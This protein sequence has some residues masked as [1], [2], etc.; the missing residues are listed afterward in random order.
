M[1]T[2]SLLAAIC[3]L[4]ACVVTLPSTSDASR[5]VRKEVHSGEYAKIAFFVSL[6]TSCKVRSDPPVRVQ[7]PPLH[8]TITTAIGQDYPNYSQDNPRYPCN[9]TLV[10]SRQVFYQSAP[11]FHGNDSFI[12]DV[13]YPSSRHIIQYDI[14]VR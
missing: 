4:A 3:L 11:D 13:R 10:G 1:R 14:E 2:L 9:A 12:I 6:T 7:Q 8:G 5:P